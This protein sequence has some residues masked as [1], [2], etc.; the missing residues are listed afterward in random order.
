MLG[1][2]EISKIR[3][4][5][6]MFNNAYK[7]SVSLLVVD[8]I[9]RLLEYV[10]VGARFSNN[11]LQCF[12]TYLKKLPEKIGNKIIIIGT[13][14]NAEILKEL[15]VWG[16]FNLK[17]EVPLLKGASDIQNALRQMIPG[18]DSIAKIPIE[19]NY[20]IGI[21]NLYFVANTISQ[22]LTENPR[23]DAQRMFMELM[24]QTSLE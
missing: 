6:N 9:E 4:V 10:H 20:K 22:K 12:L 15:G 24:T 16:C 17:V 11:M 5:Q 19:P 18:N 23:T 1:Q 13:T 3:Y 8:D 2:T 21:K 7:S 14:S